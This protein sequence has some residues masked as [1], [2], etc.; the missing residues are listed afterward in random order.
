MF[1]LFWYNVLKNSE[2]DRKILRK[3]TE[4][5]QKNDNASRKM[6]FLPPAK[7]QFF[8][9]CFCHF[10]VIFL[11]FWYNFLKNSEKDRK[12]L[13]KMTEKW[14]K[15]DNASRK[16]QFLPPAK[17][18]FF[19]SFFCHFVEILSFFCHFGTIFSKIL[20]KI[21]KIFE[22]WQKNDKQNWNDKKKRQKNDKKKRQKNDKKND[23]Q[24]WNDKKND[25]KMTKKMTDKTEMT[26]KTTKKWQKKMTDKTEMTKKMTKKT[27][28][29][30]QNKYLNH[31]QGMAAS[32]F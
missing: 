4:K 32:F 13:R 20:K 22:K 8:L 25:K 5:W 19:W 30:W 15:N 21:E 24:N 28:K 27:T 23:R 1:L 26:K 10:F 18:Q 12:I 3:M 29:K 7:W 14:Q 11:S 17:A 9:S 16:M 31:L 6:Q 2:K